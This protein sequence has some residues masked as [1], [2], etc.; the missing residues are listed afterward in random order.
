M[1]ETAE[2]ILGLSLIAPLLIPLVIYIL[3]IVA[4][5]QMFTKAGEPGWKSIIPIYNIYI[6]YKISWKNPTPNFWIW[7]IASLVSGIGSGAASGEATAAGVI[8]A[9]GVIV[10]GIWYIRASFKM[11]KAY[12]KGVGCAIL[13]IFFPSIMTLYYGFAS[14]ATYEGQQ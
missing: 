12:N 14:S 9:I 4:Y 7:F 6:A 2:G 8:G 11:A 3:A 13:G 1:T 10:A 5:W